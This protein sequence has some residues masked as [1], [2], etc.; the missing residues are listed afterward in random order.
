MCITSEDIRSQEESLVWEILCHE[1]AAKA[2]KVLDEKKALRLFD[3][4][5]EGYGFCPKCTAGINNEFD[6]L[7]KAELGDEIP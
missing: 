1:C 7:M 2:E 6:R 4:P 5:M 3:I